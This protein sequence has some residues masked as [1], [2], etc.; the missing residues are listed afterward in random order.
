MVNK[1]SEKES[2]KC[3]ICGGIYHKD[4]LVSAPA[5]LICLYCIDDL[6]GVADAKRKEMDKPTEAILGAMRK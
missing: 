5:L 3:S 6:K 2:G 4:M 1:M